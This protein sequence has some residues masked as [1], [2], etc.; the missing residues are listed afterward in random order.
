MGWL[1][2]LGVLIG[3]AILPIGIS[4]T[5]RAGGAQVQALIGPLRL[6]VYPKKKDSSRKKKSKGHKK[7]TV[8]SPE[9]SGGSLKDFKPLV[10][11]I[12]D[13]LGEAKGKFRVKRLE[14]KLI[15]AGDDPCDLAVNYGRAWA[16]VGNLLPI[17]ERHFVIKKRDVDVI[18]DFTSDETSVYARA[19][20]TITV[21]RLLRLGAK[22]GIPTLREY[23]NILK[24][25]KGG[26][27]NESK[28]S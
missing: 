27:N 3:I 24:L 9:K 21:A 6:T 19:D 5:Y 2:A 12:I 16:A 8:K 14:L 7:G 4:A 28:T 17:L 22:H 10:K 20:L 11:R 15:L 1:I 26:A 25:R 18:C 23:F 13:F